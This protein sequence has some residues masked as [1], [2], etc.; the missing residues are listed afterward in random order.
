MHLCYHNEQKNGPALSTTHSS[1]QK[2][3]SFYSLTF[4]L[5][6]QGSSVS[7]IRIPM[8]KKIFDDRISYGQHTAS[9]PFPERP[10]CN[11]STLPFSVLQQVEAPQQGYHCE[12][13]LRTK[14]YIYF[15][16]FPLNATEVH[17]QLTL[18]LNLSSYD[19]L[20]NTFYKLNCIYPLYFCAV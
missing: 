16:K 7:E 15:F 12:M 5:S 13:L 3:P 20:S 17:N 8:W 9:R 1:H 4:L 10:L 11:G 14:N 19:D 2:W 18:F 6:K